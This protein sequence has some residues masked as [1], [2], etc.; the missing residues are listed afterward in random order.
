MI[1]WI[2]ETLYR[3]GSEVSPSKKRPLFDVYLFLGYTW[4]SE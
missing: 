3:A 4:A 1:E 2:S